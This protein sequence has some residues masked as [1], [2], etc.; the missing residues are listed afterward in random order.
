MLTEVTPNHSFK[1]PKPAGS[2]QVAAHP[3]GYTDSGSS[4][5]EKNNTDYILMSGQ[6]PHVNFDGYIMS[7]VS[8]S[9]WKYT[10]KMY[11]VPFLEKLYKYSTAYY[12]NNYSIIKQALWGDI[13]CW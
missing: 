9:S 3:V 6:R 2:S 13:N 11:P 4:C 1:T 7:S 5:G 10:I 8:T 12:T